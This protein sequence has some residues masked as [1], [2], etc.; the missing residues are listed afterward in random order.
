MQGTPAFVAAVN[1]DPDVSLVVH[2]GDIHSGKQYCTEAYNRA[3]FNLWK[4]FAD[5]LVYIPGD[6]EWSDCHKKAQGG[7][8]YNATTGQIDYVLDETGAQADYAGG[9]P[10]ANLALV[11][12]LFFPQPGLTLGKKPKAVISQGYFFDRGHPADAQF[13]ENVIWEQSEV[14]FVTVNLPGGSNNDLDVW[15]GTPTESAA[16]ATER[17]D[18]T[19]AALRWLGFAFAAAKFIGSKGVVIVTQ[20]DM[21]DNEKGPSH[22]A[23]FEPVVSAIAASTLAFGRPVLMLNGDS[24]IYLSDNPLSAADPLNFVHPGYDVPNFHR[25]VV[26]GS[27]APLEWLR[28][29]VDPGVN[30][31]ASADAFGPFSWRRVVP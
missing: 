29:S 19:G 30:V 20:A 1:A 8:V 6:N 18:R 27:T 22:E 17:S 7:G 3:V 5:P 9:D 25:I 12:S 26:H 2:V 21:W 16:Q 23:G 15:Y 4:Q 13:V 28:L 10:M 11:R 31:P 14:L 24:H